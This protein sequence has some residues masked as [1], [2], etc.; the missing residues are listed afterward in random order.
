MRGVQFL[1][2]GARRSEGQL[3]YQRL[4]GA[5]IHS[6]NIFEKRA[7]VFLKIKILQSLEGIRHIIIF[8]GP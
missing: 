3:Q 8:F 5:L 1:P 2:A 4:A 7:V 6:G